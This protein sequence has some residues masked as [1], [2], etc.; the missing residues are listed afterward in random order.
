MIN[1][2]DW[3]AL[4]NMKDEEIDFSDIAETDEDF[5]KDAEIVLPTVNLSFEIEKDLADW[6]N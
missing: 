3:E 4:K 5:W 2:T 1:K 6:L